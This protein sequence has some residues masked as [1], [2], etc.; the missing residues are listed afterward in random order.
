MN[1]KRLIVAIIAGFVFSFATDFLIHGVWLA[2][3][4]KET[5]SLWRTD[6]EMNARFAWMI[7]AHLLFV[8]VFATLWAK[9]LAERGCVTSAAMFGLFM[10]LFFQ[11]DTLMTYVVSPLPADIAIKWFVSGLV[12]T[13]LLG[14][15]VSLV[16]KPKNGL[17]VTPV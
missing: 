4:Y 7:V 16:Y 10:G 12:Q 15:L 13:V 1:P 8:A 6:I 3:A 11:S 2:P 14:I 9:G 5:A 17:S